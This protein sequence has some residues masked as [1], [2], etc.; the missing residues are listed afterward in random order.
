M[1]NHTL[2]GGKTVPVVF[3]SGATEELHVRQIKLVEYRALVALLDDEF[4]L[5]AR[6]TGKKRAEIETLQPESYQLVFD[7]VRE[8][9]EKGFFTFTR[10]QQNAGNENLAGLVAAGMPLETVVQLVGAM[11]KRNSPGSSATMPPPVA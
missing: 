10:R 6:V 11:T 4:G 3:E 8:V 1:N 7:A 5:V 9:N 2:F